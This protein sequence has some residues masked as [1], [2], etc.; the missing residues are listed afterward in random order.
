VRQASRTLD[1][2]AQLMPDTAERTLL[3]GQTKE[4]PLHELEAGDR[5]LVRPGAA[6]AGDGEIVEAKS[7]VDECMIIG[8]SKPLG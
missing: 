2:L 3:D 6:V 1:E 7:V 8:E 5:V 4:V